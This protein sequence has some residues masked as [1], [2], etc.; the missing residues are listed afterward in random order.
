MGWA[1]RHTERVD[2]VRWGWI[3]P[4][5]AQPGERQLDRSEAWYVLPDT[6]AMSVL[7]LTDT[8]LYVCILEA[9]FGTEKNPG[10]LA[11]P[12]VDQDMVAMLDNG[13]VLVQGACRKGHH[14]SAVLDFA[15]GPLAWRFLTTLR[16]TFESQSGRESKG[17]WRARPD[18]LKEM[19][20]WTV[21]RGGYGGPGATYVEPC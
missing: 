7:L 2:R 4:K 17:N 1:K 21:A 18:T 16:D 5:Y 20:E 15:P 12:L 8:T 19:K 3:Y 13:M 9:P 10:I 11:L 6:R 14:G